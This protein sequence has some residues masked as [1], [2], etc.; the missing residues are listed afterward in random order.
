MVEWLDFID[1]WLKISAKLD[2][3]APLVNTRSK[4]RSKKV[5]ISS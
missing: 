2:K 4:K 3:T 1:Q 5:V